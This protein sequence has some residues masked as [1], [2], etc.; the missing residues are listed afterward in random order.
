VTD[1]QVVD[2]VLGVVYDDEAQLTPEGLYGRRKITALLRRQGLA[3]SHHGR[4]AD[5]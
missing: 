2:A 3:V 4:P 1:A 5:A